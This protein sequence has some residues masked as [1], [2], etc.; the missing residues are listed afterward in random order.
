MLLFLSQLHNSRLFSVYTLRTVILSEKQTKK[1]KNERFSGWCALGHGV[2][3]SGVSE[4]LVRAPNWA[5]EN[6]FEWLKWWLT[7]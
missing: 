7:S 4:R 6:G 5:L 2:V 3:V 1:T